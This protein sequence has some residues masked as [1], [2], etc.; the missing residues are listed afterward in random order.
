MN[1][2]DVASLRK[3]VGEHAKSLQSSQPQWHQ[4]ATS[5]TCL[6][7]VT[8]GP[9]QVTWIPCCSHKRNPT[10]NPTKDPTSEGSHKESQV[11]IQLGIPQ[12]IPCPRDPAKNSR[13]EGSH[14]TQKQAR[15]QSADIHS[16]LANSHNF[17]IILEPNVKDRLRYD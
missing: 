13:S 7:Q 3:C 10:E 16:K 5:P 4:Q 1:L 8:W 14:K 15:D 2:Q 17:S 12:R 9:D 6:S 11:G